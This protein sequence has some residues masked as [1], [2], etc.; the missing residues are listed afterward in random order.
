M[1]LAI[2][3]ICVLLVILP[4]A[5][6]LVGAVTE[7]QG[8]PLPKKYFY[9]AWIL[10]TL[11]IIGLLALLPKCSTHDVEAPNGQS[12]TEHYEPRY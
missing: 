4:F 9:P 7:A 8:K 12:A 10:T 3:F 6:A 11:A 5:H 2:A 1:K